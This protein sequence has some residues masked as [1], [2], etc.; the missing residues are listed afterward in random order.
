MLMVLL[1][2]I[3]QQNIYRKQLRRLDWST[4]KEMGWLQMSYFREKST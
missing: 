1:H 3:K 2:F 4:E